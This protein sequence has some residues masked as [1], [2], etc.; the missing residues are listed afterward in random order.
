VLLLCRLGGNFMVA[1]A[2][3]PF[4]RIAQ[5]LLLTNAAPPQCMTQVHGHG[6]GTGCSWACNV[7]LHLSCILHWVLSNH[8]ALLDLCCCRS[9][10]PK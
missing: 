8:T 2:S 6:S 3:A 7:P 9:T 5:N 10:L 1:I 4:Q